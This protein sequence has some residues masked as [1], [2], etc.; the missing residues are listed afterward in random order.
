M[1]SLG[2]LIT[3]P[4]LV[5]ISIL[6][7]LDS[8]GPVIFSQVR[9]GKGFRPFKMYKFRTMVEEAPGQGLPLTVGQDRPCDESGSNLAEVQA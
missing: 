1:A 8:H 5:F 6:I 2:L 3:W 9:V 4:L 7:K